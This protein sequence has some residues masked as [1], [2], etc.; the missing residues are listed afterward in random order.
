[1]AQSDRTTI[2]FTQRG[3]SFGDL[4]SPSER[5]LPARIAAGI[6]RRIITGELKPGDRLPKEIE[7]LAQLEVSRTTLREAL[8]ILSSKG[9]LEARQ[10]VGTHVRAPEHWNMLDPMVLGWYGE[11]DEKAL[12]QDLFEMRLA[13]EP[14]AARLAALRATEEDIAAIKAALS[15]MA[16]DHKNPG[17]AIAADIAFHLRII[18]AARNRFLL[19]VSAV[20]RAALAISVPRTFRKHGGMSRALAMHADIANAI[21]RRDGDGAAL[22]MKRLLEDTYD[23]NFS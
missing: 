12:A 20:I 11:G 23:R 2:D 14:Q 15:G 19:P 1:M 13:L 4:L 21:E 10:R 9:F 22:A 6:G 7:L 8:T 18:Q 16:D 17:G 3:D 5:G